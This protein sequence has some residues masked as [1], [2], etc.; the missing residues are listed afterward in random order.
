MTDQV[1]RQFAPEF[2]ALPDFRREVS[3]MAVDSL[4]QFESLEFYRR[5]RGLD[6]PTAHLLLAGATRALLA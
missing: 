6:L 3:R 5:I 4:F 2:A 1:D